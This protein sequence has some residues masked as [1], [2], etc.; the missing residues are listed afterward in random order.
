MFF[1]RQTAVSLISGIRN[2]VETH[3]SPCLHHSNVFIQYL[4]EVGNECIFKEKLVVNGMDPWC[5]T[6][7]DIGSRSPQ[8][9]PFLKSVVIQV[10]EL[11]EDSVI[12]IVSHGSHADLLA[13]TNCRWE[14]CLSV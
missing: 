9:N 14:H 6:E 12:M 1:L 2:T 7:S 4:K 10:W 8:Q 13:V 11:Q 5:L 3:T